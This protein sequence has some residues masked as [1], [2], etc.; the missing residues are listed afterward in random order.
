MILKL[1]KPTEE[2][3]SHRP[4]ALTSIPAKVFE[5]IILTRLKWFPES[6]NLLVAEQ[7]GFRNSMS[8][9]NSLMRF[10]QDV[11]QGFRDLTKKRAPLQYPQILKVLTAWYGEAS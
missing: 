3:E 5:R 8:K 10:V 6:Q 11:K 9:S 2:M 4:I 1:G 7:A